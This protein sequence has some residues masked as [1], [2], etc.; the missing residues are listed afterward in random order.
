[1]KATIESTSK[2]LIWQGLNF[3][4]WEGVSAK[5]IK[6]V[7]LVNRLETADAD[8]MR[9]LITELAA[10][11]KDPEQSTPG[12]LERLGLN[13]GVPADYAPKPEPPTSTGA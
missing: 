13:P 7:A 12:A 1:M 3:R 11:S 9:L 5:G 8:Q 2:T 10:A 4:V 6:F